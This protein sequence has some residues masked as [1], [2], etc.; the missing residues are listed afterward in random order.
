MLKK[1]LDFNDT[2]T[3][4][5]IRTQFLA[6]MPAVIFGFIISYAFYL[7]YAKFMP[8]AEYGMFGLWVSLV[9]LFAIIACLGFNYSATKFIALYNKEL[10]PRKA[11]GL[12]IFA[13]SI[14]LIC[15]VVAS[16]SIYHFFTFFY[17]A[18]SWDVKIIAHGIWLLP[19]FTIA[20]LNSAF[21]SGYGL[22]LYSIIPTQTLN[23]VIAI[24][25]SLFLFI[26]ENVLTGYEGMLS[27]S[28]AIL[29]AVFIQTIGLLISIPKSYLLSKPSFES[30]SWI[31]TSLPI[32]LSNASFF[33]MVRGAPL[34]I[35][36]LAG[37]K[38]VGIYFIAF[39]VTTIIAMPRLALIPIVSQKVVTLFHD[40]EI[41]KL[42]HVIDVGATYCF[43]TSLII[44]I[45][46]FFA[47]NTFVNLL[48]DE[49]KSA[50]PVIDILIIAVMINELATISTQ[51]LNLTGFQKLSA[52]MYGL[53]L[54]IYLFS[55]L[56][57]V[58]EYGAIGA[59][60]AFLISILIN[61]LLF[62]YIVYQKMKINM[63][64]FL[65]KGFS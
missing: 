11:V 56:I 27:L 12:Y 52:Y 62:I 40:N 55:S 45:I 21:L 22:V 32:Y 64:R 6:G 28:I 63:I 25:L 60:L 31:R 16:F 47:S 20:A 33:A 54:A 3:H 9:Q 34:I 15:S 18:S 35:T 37:I 50:L 39:Q 17:P 48:G 41:K 26:E 53:T 46:I 19:L 51:M 65:V 38:Q 43:Y 2:K 10:Q 7:L 14:S 58:T 5:Y 29:I 23:Y 8:V 1:K 44:A 24:L 57:L 59:A 49:Y 42:Q 36:A 4:T 30:M 13:L 61:K